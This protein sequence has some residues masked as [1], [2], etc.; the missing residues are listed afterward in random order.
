M[1]MNFWNVGVTEQNENGYDI[2]S[3]DGLPGE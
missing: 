3:F 1:T 2:V